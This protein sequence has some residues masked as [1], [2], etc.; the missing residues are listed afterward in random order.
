MTAPPL[1]KSKVEGQIVGSRHNGCVYST[2]IYIKGFQAQT[3]S[4]VSN[5][6]NWSTSCLHSLSVVNLI[7]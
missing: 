2:Y 5:R 6:L 7:K 1:V 3:K 4:H